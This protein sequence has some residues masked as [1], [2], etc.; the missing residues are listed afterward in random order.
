[1]EHAARLADE[2]FHLRERVVE[3]G[4]LVD[5]AVQAQFGG[6]FHLL[7]ENLRLFF[8][9]TLVV[10]S[11]ELWLFAWRMMIVQAGLADGDDFGV[12]GEFA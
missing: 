3:R 9:V 5:D 4:A 12:S 10:G 11:G 7:P 1:M 6:D 2:R 8:L